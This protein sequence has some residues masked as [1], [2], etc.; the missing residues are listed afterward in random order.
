M[1]SDSAGMANIHPHACV[2][3]EEIVLRYTLDCHPDAEDHLLDTIEYWLTERDIYSESQ[4][5]RFLHELVEY[6]YDMNGDAR[7]YECIRQKVNLMADLYQSFKLFIFGTP[8]VLYNV[9]KNEV[10][11]DASYWKYIGRVYVVHLRY[12]INKHFNNVL[13]TLLKLYIVLLVNPVPV[14]E[15]STDNRWKYFKTA[16][17]SP[18]KSLIQ[19]SHVIEIEKEIF[20]IYVDSRILR[21]AVTR[22]N[23]LKVPTGSY[24]L[25]DGGYTNDNGFLTPYRGVRA[26]MGVDPYEADV[27]ESFSDVNDDT[28]TPEVFIDQVEPSQAWTSW[29]DNLAIQMWAEYV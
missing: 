27:P 19:I 22:P 29:R 16:H 11:V 14:P 1:L 28:D 2:V 3:T 4:Y 17:I 15:D 26:Q 12:T 21:D 18:L 20:M 10:K 8:G 5:N 23:G 7:G 25:C 13:N 6:I 24:Y 9:C